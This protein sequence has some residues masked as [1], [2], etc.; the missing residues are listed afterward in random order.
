RVT[1]KDDL[2]SEELKSRL[3]ALG[4]ELVYN[5]EVQLLNPKEEKNKDK[6]SSKKI[7]NKKKNYN[8]K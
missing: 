5:E 8:K 4:L 6:K 1:L 3:G 2:L 7:I